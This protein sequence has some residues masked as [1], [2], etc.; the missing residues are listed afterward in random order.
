MMPARVASPWQV[1]NFG[2]LQ[3]P[4]RQFKP[5]YITAAGLASV[6]PKEIWR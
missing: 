4:S 3:Q 1:L 2:S 6:H 5:R